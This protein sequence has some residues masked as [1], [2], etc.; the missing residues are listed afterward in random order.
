MHISTHTYMQAFM[1]THIH[2]AE[3]YTVHIHTSSH[4]YT[5][6]GASFQHRKAHRNPDPEVHY[7]VLST[8]F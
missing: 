4:L 1:H 6:T 7:S 2:T 8:G 3:T 5:N